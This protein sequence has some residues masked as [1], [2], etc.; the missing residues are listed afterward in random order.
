M[1]EDPMY[2]RIIIPTNSSYKYVRRTGVDNQELAW[3]MHP[4]V[5][6]NYVASGKGSRI[7]GEI[8]EPFE[9]GDLIF[10]QPNVPPL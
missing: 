4:E 8:L 10:V 3:H 5:E 2:E 7:V 9:A 1:K 6:I